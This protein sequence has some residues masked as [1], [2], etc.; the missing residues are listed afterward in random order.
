MLGGFP[1][2]GPV[3]EA[4]AGCPHRRTHVH[5]KP[6]LGTPAEPLP[7]VGGREPAQSVSQKGPD[8]PGGG[9]PHPETG[10][11]LGE[12]HTSRVQPPPALAAGL[13]SVDVPHPAR[14]EGEADKW[15]HASGQPRDSDP[16]IGPPEALGAPALPRTPR[17]PPQSW[18][19]LGTG[20]R[21][22]AHRC[23]PHG[24]RSSRTRANPL[25]VWAVVT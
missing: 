24:L 8:G 15:A 7:M 10:V 9:L 12:S 5:T 13:A 25:P 1:G 19:P 4:G 11:S 6:S 18:L 16:L 23:P 21:S 2:P 14:R 3:C 22:G 17:S 20:Q